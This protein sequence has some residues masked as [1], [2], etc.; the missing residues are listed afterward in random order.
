VSADTSGVELLD[1]YQLPMIINGREFS[2]NIGWIVKSIDPAQ[3]KLVLE[4]AT[5]YEKEYMDGRASLNRLQDAFLTYDQGYA[6]LD[7]F[8]AFE[9]AAQSTQNNINLSGFPQMDAAFDYAASVNGV[10]RVAQE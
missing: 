1:L 4:A 8:A 6:A 5:Y 10:F 9:L 2:Q 3:D 7:E